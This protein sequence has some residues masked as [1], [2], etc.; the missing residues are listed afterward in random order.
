MRFA[1]PEPAIG[2]PRLD[3]EGLELH[4]G[5]I[6]QAVGRVQHNAH[7]ADEQ[8]AHDPVRRGQIAR[9]VWCEEIHA[10]MIPLPCQGVSPY[11]MLAHRINM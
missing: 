2:V 10:H 9:E 1:Y 5:A 4:K 7:P 3:Q 6:R 8:A 11:H